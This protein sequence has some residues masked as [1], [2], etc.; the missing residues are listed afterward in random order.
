MRRI[1]VGA[2]TRGYGKR[3]ADVLRRAQAAASTTAS[4][5]E[6]IE[7]DLLEDAHGSAWVTD[8][9]IEHAF[10]S[11]TFYGVV[12]QERLRLILGAI[13]YQLHV[14][15]PKGEHPVFDYDAL[16]IEHILPRSWSQSW[17]I[18]Y[19]NEAMGT[20]RAQERDR[21]VNRI[22]NLTLVTTPLN[23]AMSNQ[24]EHPG[25]RATAPPV[26]GG[27]TGLSWR[28][29]SIWCRLQLSRQD[30]PSGRPT[31]GTYT[32]P[33]TV[34]DRTAF[35]VPADEAFHLQMLLDPLEKQ[36]DLPPRLV[37]VG[38][39]LPH[40][41][42]C[43]SSRTRSSAAFPRPSSRPAAACPDRPC[44]YAHWSTRSSGRSTPRSGCRRRAHAPPDSAR[45]A[46]GGSTK[47]TPRCCN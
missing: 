14:E 40:P 19:D 2:N 33:P 5:V 31:A 12:G 34:C 3:F 17:S 25:A 45:S 37:Q 7:R 32:S 10:V 4:I 20:L 8:D 24:M 43:C 23:P 44:G 6:A 16:Q 28:T 1:L 35:F 41:T 29:R 30:E 26:D 9:Q 13:D 15:H 47:V 38:N 11:R 42:S 39:R 18:Q 36:L 22:G 46:S 27:R 21:A